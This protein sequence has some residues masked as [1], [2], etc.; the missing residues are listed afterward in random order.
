M[1]D[2]APYK[3]MQGKHFEGP[4]IEDHFQK[5]AYLDWLCTPPQERNPKSKKAFAEH[6]GIER[7]TLYRW[8]DDIEFMKEWEKRYYK[9]IGNPGRKQ[10][11][12]DTLYRTATDPDDPKHVQAADKYFA[13][14]GSLK[15]QKMEVTVSKSAND[16]TDE[17]LDA[18]I[19]AHAE[20][21]Q[22]KR[23]MEQ[24]VED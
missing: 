2:A 13:I 24:R 16:L 3:N 12:M 21:E 22:R 18:M 11:I 4:P 20:T 23:A 14:E 17:A 6:L 5:Q 8:E 10:E 9:T 15:P 19:A 7:K 1:P